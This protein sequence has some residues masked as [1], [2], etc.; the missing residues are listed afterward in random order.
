MGAGREAGDRAR[1]VEVAH[2]ERGRRGIL[3]QERDQFRC[4]QRI[5]AEVLEKILD[6]RHRKTP[7][8]H[9]REGRGES[10]LPGIARSDLTGGRRHI[11]LV[12]Q[13]GQRGAVEFSSG[14]RR[15]LVQPA[16]F[17]R[18][19]VVG[20][21]R[22]QLGAHGV[23][24]RRMGGRLRHEEGHQCGVARVALQA[25]GGSADAVAERQLRFDFLQLDAMA[26]DFHLGIVAS[27]VEEQAVGGAAREVAGA[28]EPAES[29]M[30]DK[31]L[32]GEIV[33]LTIAAREPGTAET[34]FAHRA[35][36]GR[37]KC[38][39]EHPRLQTARGHSDVHGFTGAN[40]AADGSDGALRRPVA[41]DERTARRPAVSDFLWQWL[42]ADVE[43]TQVGQLARGVQA[44]GRTQ[45]R[46]RRTKNRDSLP[47]QPADEVRSEAR[48]VVVHHDESRA[49]GERQPRFLDGR[50]IRR[51]RSLHN[52]VVGSQLKFIAVGGDEVDDT[53]VLDEHAFRPARCARGVDDVGKTSGGE[54]GR[55]FGRAGVDGR[56]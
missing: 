4:G 15:Q 37:L 8:Q 53:A 22:G 52:A 9:L 38:F 13:M 30:S 19:H 1:G 18:H 36:C 40:R 31:F 3:A 12:M 20:Q 29:R 48:G 16:E 17:H 28:I 45:Q 32:R 7:V 56:D 35:V 43:Q 11:F 14:R 6:H 27:V 47:A 33:A 39:V 51:R 23:G 25:A 50:I 42:A 26:A 34:Q 5:T 2:R 21:P 10:R 41:V 54:P 24:P 49:R 44:T 55:P 46:G